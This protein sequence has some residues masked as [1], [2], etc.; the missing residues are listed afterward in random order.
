MVTGWVADTNVWSE[1]AKPNGDAAVIDWMLQRHDRVYMTLV[2]VAEM[3]YGVERLPAGRRKETLSELVDA[4]VNDVKAKDRL[5]P[6]TEK[7]MRVQ[8]LIRAAQRAAG[9]NGPDGREPSFEDAL[10]AAVARTHGLAVATRNVKDFTHTGID[11]VS[12]WK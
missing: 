7:V 8:A 11:V 2:T 4:L 3:R 6:I 12:P 9:A 5:L 10:V 1:V